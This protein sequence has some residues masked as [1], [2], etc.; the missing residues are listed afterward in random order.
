MKV[1]KI[2][3]NYSRSRN[4]VVR[5]KHANEGKFFMDNENNDNY[6]DEMKKKC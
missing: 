4:N 5:K 3:I 2:G 1:N 6:K